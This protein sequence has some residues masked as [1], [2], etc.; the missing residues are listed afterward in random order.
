MEWCKDRV[1]LR[2]HQRL[3]APTNWIKI[4]SDASTW[5]WGTVCRGITTG[6]PWSQDKTSYH[7]NYL[8]ILAAFLALQSFMKDLP[9]SLTVYLYMDN[10]SLVCYLNCREGTT[11]PSLNHLAKETW[12]WCMSRNISLVAN[13]LPGRLKTIRVQ[14]D[15]GQMGFA[16]ASQY[17]PQGPEGPVC[18]Q[19][20]MSTT[21][22]FQLE[23]RS[24]GSSN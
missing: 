16:I 20:D 11:S 22:I 18:T 5:G 3:V 13:H 19:T 10:T 23:T 17:L 2:N 7:I 21:N 14:D 8:E 12:K 6:G 9:H 1:N 24:S 15:K 4:T